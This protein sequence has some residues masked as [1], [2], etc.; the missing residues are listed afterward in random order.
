M[1]VMPDPT[2]LLDALARSDP[3][4]RAAFMAAFHPIVRAAIQ[5]HQRDAALRRLRAEHFP[6][7]PVT[8]AAM[9]IAVALARYEA[10]GWR[11]DR[12]AAAC[13]HAP[14]SIRATLRRILATGRP[15]L[16]P[17]QIVEIMQSAPF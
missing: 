8:R 11:F 3:D 2:R 10:T 15:L 14:G 4:D 17:R 13:P 1:T 7:L 9:E 5:R 16:K 6:E 12:D